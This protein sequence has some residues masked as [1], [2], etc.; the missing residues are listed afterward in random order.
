MTVVESPRKTLSVSEAAKFFEKSVPWMRWIQSR[1]GLLVKQDGTPIEIARTTPR[2]AK[3]GYR[4]YTYENI[5]DI[6][7][8]LFRAGKI[9]T[10]E[11][12]AVKERVQAFM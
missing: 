4:R 1:P 12:N 3:N 9:N 5:G 8:A 7:E 10:A 6:A 2:R 11:Y